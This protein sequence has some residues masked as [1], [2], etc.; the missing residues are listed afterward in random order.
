MSELPHPV[1]AAIDIGYSG[2]VAFFKEG[3]LHQLW[4]MPLA[5][6]KRG[7]KKLDINELVMLL[8]Y[9]VQ[10][11]KWTIPVYVE[12]VSA[13]PGQG[14]TS[15]F[16]FGFQSGAVQGILESFGH[17][18]RRITPQMWK[19]HLGLIG[20]EKEASRLLA[21][22]KFPDHK[23]LFKRKKDHGRADAALIGLAGYEISQQ[24]D[25]DWQ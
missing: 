12:H 2:A 4:D 10:S 9:R 14:V 23:D 22:E 13:M 7:K 15:M 21:I 8:G 3:R 25:I 6:T 17:E 16:N 19:K 1:F 24:R 18:V 20:Q 5:L 11:D